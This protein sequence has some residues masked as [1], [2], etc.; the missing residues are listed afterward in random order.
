MT[1][2]PYGKSRR[3]LLLMQRQFGAFMLLNT[4]NALVSP[5]KKAEEVKRESVSITG[6]LSQCPIGAQGR[7]FLLLSHLSL[8]FRYK[9]FLFMHAFM[10][11]SHTKITCQ[12][13]N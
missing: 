7:L 5:I 8:V 1:T 9:Y 12:D 3:Y 10:T 11:I 4:C 13:L 6:I 2:M